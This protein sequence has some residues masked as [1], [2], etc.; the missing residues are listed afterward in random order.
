ML[1]VSASTARVFVPE[2]GTVAAFAVL[3]LTTRT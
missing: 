3:L 2:I 1:L